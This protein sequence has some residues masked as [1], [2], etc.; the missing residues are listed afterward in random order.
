MRD[1]ALGGCSFWFCLVVTFIR[2]SKKAT[3]TKNSDT[4]IT[5]TRDKNVNY[6]EIR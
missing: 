6:H 5:Q 1:N 2:D 3:I 4:T